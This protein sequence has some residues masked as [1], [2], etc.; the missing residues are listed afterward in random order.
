[1][2][3]VGFSVPVQANR[4]FSVP[5]ARKA[6]RFTGEREP[7]PPDPLTVRNGLT[8]PQLKFLRQ[9]AGLDEKVRQRYRQ[10]SPLKRWIL[11]PFPTAGEVAGQ[12]FLKAAFM[13]R[14]GLFPFP[15]FPSIPEEV[16]TRLGHLVRKGLIMMGYAGLP[17]FVPLKPRVRYEAWHRVHLTELGRQVLALPD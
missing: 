13:P 3:P 9:I 11:E 5:G 14:I 7:T 15:P 1:M 8:P 17:E 16:A 2:N 6:C 4:I 12:S 10:A